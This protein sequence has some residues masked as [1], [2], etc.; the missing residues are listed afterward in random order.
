[1]ADLI[2]RIPTTARMDLLE[3]SISQNLTNDLH[4]V[5]SAE[6]APNSLLNPDPR[7]R[8]TDD[9]PYNEYYLLR[10]FR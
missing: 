9:R 5:L 8:I 10:Y 2:N 7:I 1:M 4:E 6:I 3:W